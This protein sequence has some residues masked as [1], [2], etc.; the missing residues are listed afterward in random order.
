MPNRKD[1]PKSKTKRIPWTKIDPYKVKQNS[2][3]AQ[4]T[5]DALLTDN[6]VKEIGKTFKMKAD[7]KKTVS[8]KPQIKSSKILDGKQE[9]S[10]LIV[11]AKHARNQSYESVKK[12]ICN[13]DT[14]VLSEFFLK[15]LI[16][17]LESIENLSSLHE[18]YGEEYDN[19][20]KADQF[21]ITISTIDR[22][23]ERLKCL[24]FSQR[25]PQIIEECK[26]AMEHAINACQVVKRSTKFSKILEYILMIGNI[27]NSGSY[28][29]KAVGFDISYLTKVIL[30]ILIFLKCSLNNYEM[31]HTTL[32]L[33]YYIVHITF[34][35]FKTQRIGTI[36]MTF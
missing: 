22:V 1:W 9:R 19:F 14:E 2:L 20:T 33:E 17:I 31:F 25:C 10:L 30:F 32:P 26:K 11:L 3:W 34:Y 5:E 8:E 24:L 27:M 13:C 16:G 21:C 15:S 36:K 12:S 4:I 28:N 6:L 29:A 23:A 7:K 18:E 35:S